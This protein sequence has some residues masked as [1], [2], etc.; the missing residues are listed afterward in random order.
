[1][2]FGSIHPDFATTQNFVY[3]GAATVFSAVN[4]NFQG[5][6]PGLSFSLIGGAVPEPASWAILIVGFGLTGTML[7]RRRA[8]IA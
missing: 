3:N 8:V 2:S 1:M 5:N 7:H 4:E 6:N